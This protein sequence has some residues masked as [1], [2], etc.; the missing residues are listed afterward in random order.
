MFE[1]LQAKYSYFIFIAIL[2]VFFCVLD[3]IEINKRINAENEKNSSNYTKER[4]NTA[5]V[6]VL[7]FVILLLVLFL[8]LPTK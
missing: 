1:M 7:I 2:A 4:L 3:C 6:G 8:I 5:P